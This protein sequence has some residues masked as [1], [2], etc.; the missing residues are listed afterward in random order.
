MH[1]VE[2]L[3]SHEHTWPQS[4]SCNRRPKRFRRADEEP[5][6]VEC[7]GY[8]NK[9]CSACTKTNGEG[10]PLEAWLGNPQKGTLPQFSL[11]SGEHC[12]A[13]HLAQNSFTFGGRKLLK[14]N[15][16]HCPLQTTRRRM[17]KRRDIRFPRPKRH[18]AGVD[19]T[20]LQPHRGENQRRSFTHAHSYERQT[21][22]R[23]KKDLRSLIEIQSPESRIY[24]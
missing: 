21:K 12:A 24:F 2:Y 8:G 6:C 10:R 7:A 3:R 9:Y 13:I 22:I 11:Q 16:A 14:F 18:R 15:Q 4:N 19:T 5:L 17:Y 20:C 23:S 1:S